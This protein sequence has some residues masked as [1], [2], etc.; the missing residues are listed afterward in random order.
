[1]KYT[2]EKRLE[3]LESLIFNESVKLDSTSVFN[4]DPIEREHYILDQLSLIKNGTRLLGI[5]NRG[6]T[7]IVTKV[8]DDKYKFLFG[9]LSDT[10][11]ARSI[12]RDILVD[13][14]EFYEFPKDIK[15]IR[16]NAIDYDDDYVIV[17]RNNKKIFSGENDHDPMKREPW[18]FNSDL[19]F[20]W[21]VDHISNI[22]Y[23]RV[24][25]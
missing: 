3:R 15:F 7:F 5:G 22:L 9:D 16:N 1:M 21:L 18:R 24:K 4:R 13:R 11:N 14:I 6:Y 20:Y 10:F 25:V 12:V 23:I 19:G 17:Y 8:S 2:L